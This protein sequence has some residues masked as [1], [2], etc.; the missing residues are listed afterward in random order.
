MFL[1]TIIRTS[2]RTAL[3]DFR[4]V[5]RWLSY[6]CKHTHISSYNFDF[7]K[8]VRGLLLKCPNICSWLITITYELETSYTTFSI[9]KNYEAINTH[10]TVKLWTGI[11]GT[12]K[13]SNVCFLWRVLAQIQEKLFGTLE[14]NSDAYYVGWMYTLW[15]HFFI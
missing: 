2:T 8:V 1:C 10:K 11:F 5:F 6:R 12:F 14:M 7:V 13:F 15:K 3:W 9:V 4:N